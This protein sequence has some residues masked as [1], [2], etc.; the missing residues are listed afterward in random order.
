VLA[1]PI[2]FVDEL[3]V[4]MQLAAAPFAEATLLRAGRAYQAHT[5][6]HLRIP[7]LEVVHG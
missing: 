4:S 2:G 5:D 7:D 1:L 6:W 3:P